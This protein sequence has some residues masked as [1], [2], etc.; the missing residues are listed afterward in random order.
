MSLR[1]QK[2]AKKK[3]EIVK[4]AISIITEKG[5]HNTTMEDIAAKLLMTKGSVYYYF[6]D[7][8]DLLYQSYKMLL[9]SSINTVADI[10]RENISVEDKLSKVMTAHIEYLIAERSGFETGINPEQFFEGNKLK[11]ILDLRSK[12]ASE[13]DRLIIEGIDSNVFAPVDVKIVRNIILGA[14]NWVI[15][16][17]SPEGEMRG[18]EMASSI[19]KYL[20]RILKQND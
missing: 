8:H 1:A 15:R 19:T 3:E 11:S 2:T 20:L 4:S 7:K 6:K 9:E 18:E 14:M 13:I 16:W 5:Y 17:Y 12:Y 10:Q